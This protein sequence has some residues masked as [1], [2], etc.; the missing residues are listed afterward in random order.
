MSVR[1]AER[2]GWRSGEAC[3]L[4]LAGPA[5][6]GKSVAAGVLSREWGFVRVSF[7]EPI[8]AMA[9][10]L[11]PAWA[12]QP[13]VFDHPLKE[14]ICPEYGVSPRQVLRRLGEG[15]RTQ[16][17]DVWNAALSRRLQALERA[18]HR[19]VVVDDVRRE[20]EAALLRSLGGTLIHV[21]RSGVDFRRD[22][23]TEMGIR[24]QAAAGDVETDNDGDLGQWV[25]RWSGFLPVARGEA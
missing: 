4:G 24:V 5:G 23:P 18:G 1:Q 25:R 21:R 16:D 19:L 9:R 8:R 10:I 17:E 2:T 3:L 7:A 13:E 15:L 6:A 22:H 14:L 20:A 11:Y 12:E